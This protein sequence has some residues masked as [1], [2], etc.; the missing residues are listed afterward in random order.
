MDEDDED[1]DP[2]EE[3]E[4]APRS[5]LLRQDRDEEENESEEDEGEEYMDLEEN[6][7]MLNKLKGKEKMTLDEQQTAKRP[8]QEDSLD[9]AME[10]EVAMDLQHQEERRQRRMEEWKR[11]LA[12]PQA[13]IDLIIEQHKSVLSTKISQLMK[14]NDWQGTCHQMH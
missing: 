2:Y 1:E 4:V 13:L 12:R 5:L 6:D 14:A 7:P 10:A 11:W 8:R 9:V 3:D